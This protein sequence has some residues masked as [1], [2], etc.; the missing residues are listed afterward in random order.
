[1]KT[2]VQTKKVTKKKVNTQLA[3]EKAL[4]KIVDSIKVCPVIEQIS[5]EDEDWYDLNITLRLDSDAL[6]ACLLPK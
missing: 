6:G 3:Q 5:E 1:M 2:S 4:N